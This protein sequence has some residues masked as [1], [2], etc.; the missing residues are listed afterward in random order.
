MAG[1]SAKEESNDPTGLAAHFSVLLTGAMFWGSAWRWQ[2]F[3]TALGLGPTL[4]H[5]SMSTPPP[6]AFCF[7]GVCTLL[8]IVV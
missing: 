1:H 8:S 3:P 7:C 6:R 4:P 5:L 2:P